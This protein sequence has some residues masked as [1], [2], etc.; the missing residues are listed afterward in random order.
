MPESSGIHDC[1]KF[2]LEASMNSKYISFLDDNGPK[3]GIQSSS[4]SLQFGRPRSLEVDRYCRHI[5]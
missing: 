2:L 1:I 4:E 5:M 3:S